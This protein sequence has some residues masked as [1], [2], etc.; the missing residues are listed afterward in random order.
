MNVQCGISVASITAAATARRSDSAGR[1][2]LAVIG[3]CVNGG[4]KWIRIQCHPGLGQV[5][6]FPWL[7]LSAGR[8]TEQ[9]E[10]QAGAAKAF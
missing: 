9:R 3:V 10:H 8:Q 2:F 6:S 7:N 4:Q 5:T 1:S